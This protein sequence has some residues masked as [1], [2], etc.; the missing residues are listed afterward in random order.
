M[1]RILLLQDDTAGY[2][3]LHHLVQSGNVAHIQQFID[4]F[5]PVIDMQSY[6]GLTPLHLTMDKHLEDIATVLIINGANTEIES[7]DGVS[8]SSVV[9]I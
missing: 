3:A 8:W 4:E 2:T 7:M 6:S 9:H 5:H 1:T